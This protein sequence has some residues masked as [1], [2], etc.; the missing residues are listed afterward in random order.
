[1][2][3]GVRPLEYASAIGTSHSLATPSPLLTGT[4]GGS[5]PSLLKKKNRK[6]ST[7]SSVGIRARGRRHRHAVDY[8]RVIAGQEFVYPEPGQQV[9]DR[10]AG[11]LLDGVEPIVEE[12]RREWAMSSSPRCLSA[13]G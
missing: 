5:H 13:G 1:S 6:P 12:W 8:T 3:A 10:R 4:C 9:P 7:R 2:S 11:L